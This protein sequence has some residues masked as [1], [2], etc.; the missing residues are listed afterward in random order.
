MYYAI[1][2]GIFIAT[3]ILAFVLPLVFGGP[4]SVIRL[5]IFSVPVLLAGPRV[6]QRF[7][8]GS[9][10]LPKE[11]R[12]QGG[13]LYGGG[14]G[15]IWIG[16]LLFFAS[17]GFAFYLS[18]QGAQ[19]VPVGLVTGYAMYP[20][21]VGILFVE[22]AYRLWSKGKIVPRWKSQRNSVYIVVGVVVATQLTFNITSDRPVDVLSYFEREA[23]AWGNGYSNEVKRKAEE[24]YKAEKRL[25]CVD[26]NFID[27]DSL[28][29]GTKADRSKA[30]SIAM[31]DCGRF[32]ATIHRPIDGIADGQLLFIA[33]P[34]DADAGTPLEWQCFSPQLKRIEQHTNGRCI[35]DSSLA[36]ITPAPGVAQPTVASTEQ[37]SGAVAD[38]GPT[39]QDYL[40]RLAEPTLWEDCGE[41]VVSYRLLKFDAD[42]YVAAVRVSH[43]SQEG[44]YRSVSSSSPGKTIGST[45]YVDQKRWGRLEASID[46][47]GFWHLQSERNTSGIDGS[48]IYLEACKNGT[49]HAVQRESDDSD[50]AAT[51]RTFTV[52][53]KLEWLE[54]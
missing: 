19:G 7:T 8:D 32:V 21:L 42:R 54:N 27:F 14:A 10:L 53:G 12:S 50:L 47:S 28:L 44:A 1:A 40:D 49:Y 11:F 23:L 3:Y 31:L 6:A 2:V 38:R 9:P 52:I 45:G 43:D 33:S 29:R 20:Y 46:A 4:G 16:H 35:H 17:I 22:L 5:A 18:A 15:L 51:V 37:F 25:P 34:G 26:D 24:F 13:F 36:N 39:I 41:E 30:L 48:R